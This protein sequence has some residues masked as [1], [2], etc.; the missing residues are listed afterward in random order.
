MANDNPHRGL[1]GTIIAINLI[2]ALITDAELFL[3]EFVEALP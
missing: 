1:K 3:R 2:T